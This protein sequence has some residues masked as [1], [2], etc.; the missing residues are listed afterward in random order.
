[1][2]PISILCVIEYLLITTM[3]LGRLTCVSL[4]AL[5]KAA[6]VCILNI[7][8]ESFGLCWYDVLDAAGDCRS[9]ILRLFLKYKYIRQTH[10]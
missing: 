6:C 4:E 8:G 5:E 2:Y 1:M 7:S 9:T 3:V 10:P